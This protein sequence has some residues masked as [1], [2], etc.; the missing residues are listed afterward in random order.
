M[1]V[2]SLVGRRH[3]HTCRVLLSK[4][5]PSNLKGKSSSSQRWLVRQMQDPYI[6]K[7][8]RE[9]YRCRSAFKLLEINE[10]F[11]ILTPGVTAIDLG[12]APGSWTQVA[13]RAVNSH[14]KDEEKK[15]GKVFALDRNPIHHIDGATILGSADFTL[16]KTQKRLLEMLDG[17]L[18]D[19]VLS[20]MA[21]NASGVRDIDHEQIINLAYCALTFALRVSKVDGTL[22]IKLWD[23]GKSQQLEK[24][25]SK[26]YKMIKIVRPPATRDESTEKFV[27]A[28]G[29]KGL[30]T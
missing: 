26:F 20:D 23:G 3:V 27:V 15:V 28:R 17:E 1:D 10:R 7:A 9:N 6:E 29:F 24:D 18:V 30:K 12:A 4:T 11:H 22:V 8:R 25:V 19:V 13:V 16:D 14:A 21:P 5:M 2:W